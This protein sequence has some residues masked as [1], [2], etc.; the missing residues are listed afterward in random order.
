M[1][2]LGVVFVEGAA[3]MVMEL[4]GARITAPYY[5]T[6]LYVWAS[7]LGV[8]LGAL[9]LGYFIGGE[10]SRRYPG[11][12]IVFRVLLA[13]A[14]LT[15]IAPLVAPQVLLT[16]DALGVRAGSLVACMIYLL[17]PVA[18][19]GM[20]TPLVTRLC[21]HRR[22]RAGAATGTVYAVATVGGIVAT[23]VAGFYHPRRPASP[24]R[25]S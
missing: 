12:A 18:C 9:A 17:P 6:S 3:V 14:F 2:L 5:G 11:E 4:L 25:R 13:A 15:A 22:E 20:V 16:T 8:T 7:V 1:I 10:A 24:R 23:L 19:M 21:N